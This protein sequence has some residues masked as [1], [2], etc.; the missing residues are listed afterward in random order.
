MKSITKE[1]NGFTLV[2]LLIAL[3]IFSVGILGV[4]TM[5]LSSIQ[6]NSKGNRISEASNIAADRIE[7]AMAM[8]Y[9]SDSNTKDD[10]GDGLIDAADA[11]ELYIDVNGNGSFGLN[12]SPPDTDVGPISSADGNYQIYWNVAVDYPV[13]GAKTIRVIVDPPGSDPNVTMEVV[14]AKLYQ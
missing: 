10:D 6:G 1:H 4:G 8:P 11:K 5:Q 7:Q 2:E 14:K 3:F 13:A 9:D 12:D